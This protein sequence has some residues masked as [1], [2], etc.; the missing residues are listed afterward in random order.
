MEEGGREGVKV[1]TG[2]T[3]MDST[4]VSPEETA[5]ATAWRV[6]GHGRIENVK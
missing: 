1:N 5:L 6:T 3:T 2:Q 4:H